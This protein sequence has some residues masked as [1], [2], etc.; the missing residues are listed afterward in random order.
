V[1]ATQL[2]ADPFEGVQAP[3]LHADPR[4][5]HE[6]WSVLPYPPVYMRDPDN[7]LVEIS[8]RVN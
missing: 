2:R 1:G 4:T 8:G 7:N 6:D 3:R 5:G